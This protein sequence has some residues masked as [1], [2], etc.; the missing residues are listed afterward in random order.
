[1]DGI[2][3]AVQWPAMLA[4]LIAAW[5]VT[6][7]QPRKR[8]WGFWV[9]MLSNALWVLWGWHDGAHALI[10]L[11]LGLLALNIYGAKKNSDE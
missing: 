1:M 10:G 7:R 8:N 9:F 6:S 2:W 11:Q 4:T 5:L 3:D